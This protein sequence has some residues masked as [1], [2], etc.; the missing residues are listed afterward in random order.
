M[1]VYQVFC[2][3]VLCVVRDALV[4]KDSQVQHAQQL[5]TDCSK[6]GPILLGLLAQEWIHYPQ[7]DG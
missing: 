3:L 2:N 4:H 5:V 6:K 7:H 1:V